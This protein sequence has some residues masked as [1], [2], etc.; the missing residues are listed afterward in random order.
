[1]RG[2]TDTAV[3]DEQFPELFMA[4]FRLA[5]RM[6]GDR[7]AAEDVAADALTIAL[8]RWRRVGPLPYR[9]AWV[10]RVTGN[11]GLKA[12][13]RRDRLR[14]VDAGDIASAEDGFERDATLR[15]TLTSALAGLPRRQRDAVVL[16]YLGGRSEREIAEALGV[17][18]GTVKTHTSRGLAALRAAL[19]S[20]YEEVDVVRAES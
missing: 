6:L 19:G 14:V 11:L 13:R 10:L 20:D 17:S 1:M 9:L 18:S 2:D 3:F 15:V 16:R 8:V 12:A 5:Y 7:A 4:S